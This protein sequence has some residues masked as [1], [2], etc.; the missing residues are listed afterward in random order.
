[1]DVG[2]FKMVGLT[3][4]NAPSIRQGICRRSEVFDVYFK[5][6]ASQVKMLVERGY[7]RCGLNTKL[8]IDGFST[9]ENATFPAPAL[10][11]LIMRCDH[12]TASVLLEHGSDPFM[13]TASGPAIHAAAHRGCHQ[14]VGALLTAANAASTTELIR[15]SLAKDEFKRDAAEVCSDK[16]SR[17]YVRE[18]QKGKVPADSGCM[19]IVAIEVELEAG[20]GVFCYVSVCLHAF[21]RGWRSPKTDCHRSA[22]V[23]PTSPLRQV[24]ILFCC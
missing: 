14:I 16:L 1:V 24:R 11:R 4:E 23:P 7:E 21:N 9:A 2:S 8:R 5:R 20:Q 12:Y 6:F 18:A 19:S 17:C 15:L 10:S 22:S 13:H 3:K